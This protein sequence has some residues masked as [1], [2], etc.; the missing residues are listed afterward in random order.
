MLNATMPGFFFNNPIKI[1]H[2]FKEAGFTERQAEAQVEVLNDYVEHG[3]A[4]KKD[5]KALEVALKRDIKELESST[6][7]DL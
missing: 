7:R 5:L 2:H 6:K 4:T 3:L 1:L